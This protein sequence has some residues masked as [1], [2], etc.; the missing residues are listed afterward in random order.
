MLGM[1]FGCR[2]VEVPVESVDPAPVPEFKLEGFGRL[3]GFMEL[4]GLPALGLP[5]LIPGLLG[6]S[7]PEGPGTELPTEP[8]LPS[9]P[10]PML[11][12]PAPPPAALDPP[13]APAPAPPAPP[14]PPP[15]AP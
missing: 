8:E 1:P 4:P 13:A 15:P 14:P 11:P 7:E 10:L 12:L 3:P 9:L 2:V 5:A 6:T